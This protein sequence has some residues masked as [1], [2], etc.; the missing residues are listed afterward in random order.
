LLL[1]LKKG[2]FHLAI[3]AQVP[4]VCVVTSSYLNFDNKKEN[5]FLNSGKVKL[6][7]FPAYETK[8][9]TVESVNELTEHFQQF[10]QSEF[11]KLNKEMDLDPK[12][13]TGYYR[14]HK[15]VAKK[16]ATVANGDEIKKSS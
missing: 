9:L 10:M 3:Q 4:I 2:A 13:N 16:N 11:D 6:R 5:K 7:V 8:G 15:I 1:P 12:Y 14:E